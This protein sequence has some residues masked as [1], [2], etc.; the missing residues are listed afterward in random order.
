VSLRTRLVVAFGA[1]AT[2]STVGLGI[3]L[4]QDRQVGETERFDREVREAC[5]R[6]AS[7]VRRQAERDQKLVGAAC[8]TGELV[9]RTLV[10]LE[11]DDLEGRRAGLAALVPAEREAFDLDGLMLVVGGEVLGAD[12]R[13]LLR[14]SRAEVAR[15]SSG[16][17]MLVDEEGAA[18]SAPAIVSR[19]TRGTKRL[20]AGLVGRRKLDPLLEQVGATMGVE[21]RRG[22]VA[23]D[24]RFAAASC[25]AGDGKTALPIS[26]RKSKAELAANLRRI[27]ERVAYATGASLAVAFVLAL[28]LARS[29][30]RPIA[31]L[32][33]EARKVASGEARP[34]RVRGPGEI[35]E[36]SFAFDKMLEDLEATRR[37]LAAT[38]RVAAW[39]EVARSV[40]HEVKNPLAPIRAAVE[41]LRRL[42]ARDDP[43]FDEYFDE[44]TRTVLSEVHRISNIVTEF[45]R[46][47]R[48]PP[49][50]PTE[51]DVVDLVRGVVKLHETAAHGD[52]LRLDARTEV[53]VV[54]CDRDQIIQ[55][56]TNLVQNALDA[57]GAKETGEVRVSVE[58]PDPEHV[59]VVVRDDGPGVAPELRDRLFEPYATNKAHGT[60]LG[61]A[62]AQRI[63]VEHQGELTY[64]PRPEGGAAFRLLLPVEGPPP[65]SELTP[66]S[67]G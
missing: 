12:P 65:V 41:T 59:A 32:A 54:R 61:L 39:R 42:R 52:R 55:V 21:V 43:A 34:V 66:P 24:A 57:V 60:G 8:A 9:D 67:S 1:V 62:L 4:R 35:A 50:R 33:A 37:R 6:A 64:E 36:L 47:A 14:T 58:L 23:S 28:L 17:G 15:L 38:T 5:A 25:D 27:D 22:D 49:P 53:P 16:D 26:V 51:V 3:V 2:L 30:G 45:T 48:L 20:R 44:A 19:C 31:E 40:A 29:L 18:S 7:E 56:V 63:A 11:A 46:F 10:A 13:D